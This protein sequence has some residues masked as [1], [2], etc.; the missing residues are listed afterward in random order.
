[1]NNF[2]LLGI[3]V[4]EILTTMALNLFFGILLGI[5]CLGTAIVGIFNLDSQR[6]GGTAQ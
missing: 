4:M 3:L 6:N 5:V 2:L 1:M